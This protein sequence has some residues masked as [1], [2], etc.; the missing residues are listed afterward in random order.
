VS[1]RIPERRFGRGSFR[2]HGRLRRLR[3][4]RWLR[5]CGL[6]RRPCVRPFALQADGLCDDGLVGLA[7]RSATLASATL[8]SATL[9]SATLASAT[10][11]FA[12]L[13]FATLAFAT[14]AFATLA[15]DLAAP[16]LADGP[17]AVLFI[18]AGLEPSD[19]QG[20]SRSS[21]SGWS[22]AFLSP[23]PVLSH[24]GNGHDLHVGLRIKGGR[25]G[26]R[27]DGRRKSGRPDER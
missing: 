7:P 22:A 19:Q 2:R 11:A 4:L 15:S 25:P 13:A 16:G 3:R 9:A 10:L 5:G 17:D 12:T 23:R 1:Q 20:E 6:C 18:G 14:L 21:G 26:G 24:F 27:P 8:A